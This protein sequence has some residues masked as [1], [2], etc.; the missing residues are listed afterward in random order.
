MCSARSSPSWFVNDMARPVGLS[1]AGQAFHSV[2]ATAYGVS[3]ALCIS[4]TDNRIEGPMLVI[5]DEAFC[6]M[7][8]EIACR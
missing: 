5:S 4:T 7:D 3:G 8:N 6:A 2:R 1:F